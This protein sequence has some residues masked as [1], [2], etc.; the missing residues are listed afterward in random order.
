[1]S[2]AAYCRDL[3]LIKSNNPQAEIIYDPNPYDC[4]VD[5][6]NLAVSAGQ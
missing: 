5:F 2:K 1:L 4:Q 3:P 6:A